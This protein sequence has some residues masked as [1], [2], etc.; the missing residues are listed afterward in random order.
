MNIQAQP[1][2]LIKR[3]SFTTLTELKNIFFSGNSFKGKQFLVKV[4]IDGIPSNLFLQMQT[5]YAV[6]NDLGYNQT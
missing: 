4:V 1:F 3:Q 5:S 2:I 6:W